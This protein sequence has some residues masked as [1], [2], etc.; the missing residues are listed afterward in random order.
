MVLAL[1]LD[2]TSKRVA[3]LALAFKNSKANNP[4]FVRS[5]GALVGDRMQKST[6]KISSY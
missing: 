4:R 6:N 1:Q 3:G 2:D 5:R